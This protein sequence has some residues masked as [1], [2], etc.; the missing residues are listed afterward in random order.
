MIKQQHP[1][2][3]KKRKKGRR[4]SRWKKKRSP[5]SFLSFGCFFFFSSSSLFFFLSPEVVNASLF[6]MP[7]SKCLVAARQSDI[8]L[9]LS[10]R[11]FNWCFSIS[12]SP[13]SYFYNFFPI[14][15]LSILL[16]YDHPQPDCYFSPRGFW[17]GVDKICDQVSDAVVD[18]CL[19][20]DPNSRIACET[21]SKTGMIMVFG[22]ITTKT[23]LDYQKIIRGAVQEIGYDD[24]AKGFD[25]KTCNVS[26]K[27]RHLISSRATCV[28]QPLQ[29]MH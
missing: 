13:L 27:E 18:A 14:P 1:H 8:G 17:N 24:S 29:L 5:T 19:A 28:C 16:N 9:F 11:V 4:E 22:E 21:A 25:Y 20:G 2:W 23:V 26:E 6:S 10:T 15:S 7:H 12:V 3:F